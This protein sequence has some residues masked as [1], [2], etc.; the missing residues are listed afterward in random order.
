VPD[1]PGDRGIFHSLV[2]TPDGSKFVLYERAL[3]IDRTR[4]WCFKADDLTH[5]WTSQWASLPTRGEDTISNT[6]L[7][8]QCLGSNRKI[9][10]EKISMSSGEIIDSRD[11]AEYRSKLRYFSD[12]RIATFGK[13]CG[14]VDFSGVN[15]TNSRFET[16]AE[17]GRDLV[18]DNF[19]LRPIRTGDP[20]T[21][22]SW[23]IIFHDVFSASFETG[24][25]TIQTTGGTPVIAFIPEPTSPSLL[26][27]LDLIGADSGML[28][29]LQILPKSAPVSSTGL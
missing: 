29:C 1:T 23:K 24:V 12:D 16:G 9:H 22:S 7:F 8:A 5:L 19:L 25:A 15:V 10:I 21:E 28:R 18:C 11:Q 2:V 4:V 13:F 17:S 20:E 6:F 14:L 3:I 26:F 27:I